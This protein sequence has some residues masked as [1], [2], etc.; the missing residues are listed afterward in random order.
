M[1]GE[2]VTAHGYGISS[3]GDGD[4]LELDRGDGHTSS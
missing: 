1:D 2:G 4:A 3:Q